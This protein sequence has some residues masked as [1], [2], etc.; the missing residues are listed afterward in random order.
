[1]S[2]LTKK[3][4]RI[5]SQKKLAQGKRIG[6]DEGTERIANTILLYA[7]EDG[8][9]KIRL[10]AGIGVH[11]HLFIKGEWRE[12]MRIPGFAWRDLRAHFLHR[13]ARWTHPFFLEANEQRFEFEATFEREFDLPLETLTLFLLN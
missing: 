9:T 7:V 6:Q 2:A 10:R 13:S 11:A 5:K 4:I 12:L 3:A 8:A 1:M